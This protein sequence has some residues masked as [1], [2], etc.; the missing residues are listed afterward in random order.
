MRVVLVEDH[1]VIREAFASALTTA[2]LDVVGQAQ[3]A[4]EALELVERTTPNVAVLD[5]QLADGKDA[6]GLDLAETLDARKPEIAILVLSV[7]RQPAYVNRLLSLRDSRIGYLHKG[8]PGGLDNL[9]DAVHRVAAGETFVDPTL[10]RQLIGIKRTVDHPITRLTP[11]ELEVLR[12]IA[13]GRT[14]AGLAQE[15][16]IGI[17]TATHHVSS[18]FTKLGIAKGIDSEQCGFN[19]RVLAVLNYLS[20]VGTGIASPIDNT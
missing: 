5:L 14:N 9:I 18:I 2:G 11:R 20:H 8:G 4:I 12:L 1:K 17:N 10:V 3:S 15:L 6:S 13:Q 19:A 7:S 16:N